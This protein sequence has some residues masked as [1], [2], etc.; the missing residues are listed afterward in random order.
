MKLQTAITLFALFGGTTGSM[1]AGILDQFGG[2]SSSFTSG[3]YT[4]TAP[5]TRFMKDIDTSKGSNQG[6]TNYGLDYT[7]NTNEDAR[8]EIIVRFTTSGGGSGTQ[9]QPILNFYLSG[10]GKSLLIGN[11]YA[12][13]GQAGAARM[14][15]YNGD[16]ST[17]SIRGGSPTYILNDGFSTDYKSGSNY[18]TPVSGQ[19]WTVDDSGKITN[20]DHVYKI[21]IETYK[22]S[23]DDKISYLYQGPSGV[24][25]QLPR[26]VQLSTLGI[27]TITALGYFLGAN[28][29]G[30]VTVDGSGYT[31]GIYKY[32]R[33]LTSSLTPPELP[34]D[35]DPSDPSVPEPSA[36]G[37]LAGLGAIALAASR[38]RRS[39]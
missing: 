2:G 1:A 10:G 20:G 32:S 29:G 33:V 11:W 34:T 19:F 37:S 7:I 36:F 6:L 12:Q 31:S 35:P 26:E 17:G 9:G 13:N 25:K 14:Q 18:Q 3:E 30:T 38:R 24:T 8:H 5:Q 39:R 21:A 27:T 22:D 23:T 28:N 16:A 4:Y 15:L